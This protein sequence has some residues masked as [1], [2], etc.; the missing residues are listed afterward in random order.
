MAVDIG[1]SGTSRCSCY[2]STGSYIHLGGVGDIPAVTQG[3]W[4]QDTI[5]CRDNR[6]T[7]NGCPVTW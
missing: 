1:Y 5:T 7:G 4:S 2:R 3:H 6:D